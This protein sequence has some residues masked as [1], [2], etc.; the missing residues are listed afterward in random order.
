VS[1]RFWGRNFVFARSI[2]KN[3]AFGLDFQFPSFRGTQPQP[4]A[5]NSRT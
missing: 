3:K 1:M 5:R 2:R 4:V